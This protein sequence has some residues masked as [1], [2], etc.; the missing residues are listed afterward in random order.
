MA[1][2]AEA[3]KIYDVDLADENEIKK[4]D[5]VVLAVAHTEY[6]SLT[7]MDID[8]MFG[9]GKKVLIDLKGIFDRKEYEE[10]GYFYWSL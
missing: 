5:A 6:K 10:A 2:S 1:D 7:M 4:R 3:K 8:S 9:E